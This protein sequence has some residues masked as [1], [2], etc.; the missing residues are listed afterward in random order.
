[1]KQLLKPLV[2]CFIL[3]WSC[4]ENEEPQVDEIPAS[5]ES[6]INNGIIIDSIALDYAAM[7]TSSDGFPIIQPAQVEKFVDEKEILVYFNFMSSSRDSIIQYYANKNKENAEQ[8]FIVDYT[9]KYDDKLESISVELKKNNDEF[10]AFEDTSEN[11]TLIPT[12]EINSQDTFAKY[13]FSINEFTMRYANS[14]FPE[15]YVLSFDNKELLSNTYVFR[16]TFKFN[17]QK[18]FILNTNQ[19]IF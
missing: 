18:E 16:I 6:I 5:I 9:L 4:T 15:F 14:S 3:L 2:L 17:N 1:M 13:E 8:G 10:I 19:I 11:I 12:P 7:Y